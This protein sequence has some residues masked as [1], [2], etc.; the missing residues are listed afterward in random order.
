M[1]NKALKKHSFIKSEKF[2]QKFYGE[3]IGEALYKTT[4][5]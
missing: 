1:I 2:V 4:F 5:K 3:F